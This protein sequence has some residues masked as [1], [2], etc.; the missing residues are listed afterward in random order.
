[1]ANLNKIVL[2][3]QLTADPESRV[4]ME[5]LP[6]AKFS[7]AVNRGGEEVTGTDFMDIV[8]WRNLAELST[9]SLK[10]GTLALVEGRI[11]NRSYENQTGQRVWVT[12]II[13]SNVVPLD[14]TAKLSLPKTASSEPDVPAEETGGDAD[15][16][17]DLP[18]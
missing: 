10:K 1:M 13:A 18:F 3:G 15:L 14:P 11:Q 17:S 2:V 9:R 8:A 4:T 5:G 7:L 6:V 12:E 16:T